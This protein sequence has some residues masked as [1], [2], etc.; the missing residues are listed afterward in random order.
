MTSKEADDWKESDKDPNHLRPDN[1]LFSPLDTI[2]PATHRNP[3]C[4]EGH[5]E[6]CD[7]WNV[8]LQTRSL[9]KPTTTRLA[10]LEAILFD[11]FEYL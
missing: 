10:V 3:L 2:L 4:G 6:I 5:Y 8:E 1:Q 7:D 11:H 9:S